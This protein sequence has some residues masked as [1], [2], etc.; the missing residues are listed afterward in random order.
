MGRDGFGNVF[1]SIGVYRF[2]GNRSRRKVKKVRGM[3]S[4][5][6]I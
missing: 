3:V 2:F 4:R 1:R 5:S 6:W